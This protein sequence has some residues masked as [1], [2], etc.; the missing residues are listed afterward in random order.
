MQ[1]KYRLIAASFLVSSL[2]A[3][4][5][6]SAA[7][8]LVLALLYIHNDAVAYPGYYA[9]LYLY[10]GSPY[11]RIVIE[12]HYEQGINP[13]TD[14][15][16]HLQSIVHKYTGKVVDL[17]LFGDITPAMLP[18]STDNDNIST[19]GYSFLDEHARYRKA[20]SEG[21]PPCTCSM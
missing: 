7:V 2:W 10:D 4:I 13:S 18:A 15:P 12:V 5:W 19:F 8:L 9:P 16:E 1:G 14:A 20:G 17:C 6:F 3:T 21:T 11:D